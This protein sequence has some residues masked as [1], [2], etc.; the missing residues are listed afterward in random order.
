MAVSAAPRA[1]PILRLPLP[2]GMVL[3]PTALAV[4]LAFYLMPA[5]T[6]PR[7]ATR[8]PRDWQLPLASDV[9]AFMAWLVG[10]EARLGPLAFRDL[11]RGLAWLLDWPLA[12]AE[13]LLVKG[14][15]AGQGAE[16]VQMAPPLPWLSLLL[17]VTALAAHAGGW[18]LA[19]L[20]GG[21]FLYLAA[22]GQWASA[23]TT[24]A[25]IAVAVPL[26]AAAGLLLGI[27]GHRWP[28][29]ERAMAPLLDLMQTV[30]VFAYLVPILFLFGFGPVAAMIATVVYAVPPMIRV[31]IL[32]LRAV[33]EEVVSFGR[34]AGCTRRQLTWRVL[35]PVARPGLMLGL[36]QVI[37]LSLNM[38]IIAAMIGAGGLG[39]DV[40]AAL[41]RLDI[42]HGLEA[43]LAITLLAIALDRLSQGLAARAAAPP[44]HG[45]TR[46]ADLGLAAAVAA[47]LLLWGLAHP[48][49]ALATYPSA[50]QVSTA[51]FWGELVRW[52][53]VH[54]FESLEA[55][56]TAV[57]LNLLVPVKRFLLAQP[58]PWA[59]LLLA[60]AGWRLGGPRLAATVL[61]LGAFVAL[62]GQWENAAVTVYLCGVSVVI[63][64][65]VGVPLGIA[66]A[67]R[68]R[69]G[70]VLEAVLDL[71]QTLP[72]FVY[73]IPVVMLFRVG[74]FTAM[75]AIVLYALAPAARY[76]MHG[77]RQVAP[78]LVEAGVA[79][80]CTRR[81]LLTRV[82][83]PLA[84]PE[85]LLGLNQ[86]V[87]L[88]LSMLVITAL[89]GTRDL[90]QEVY[91][92]LA[93]ADVGRGV[94]AGLCVA[95]IAMI[96]DRLIAAG[97]SRLRRRLGLA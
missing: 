40:L 23:M 14:F 32:S 38:T 70:Q 18:R 56:K 96:A 19:A 68:P 95:A 20:V 60:V 48:F 27:A 73:L 34:M 61:A 6:L 45:A 28:R 5:G 65:L 12:L 41:R 77:L 59:L 30:P 89:V 63:A 2:P 82:R 91:V 78:P 71:L 84:L 83:L 94:V 97:T 53:N 79:A 37:M 81:Q 85:I 92:A 13:A 87:M 49:P 88:A 22:F 54:L 25:S 3:W 26:G 76:T 58:W 39:F 67:A 4:S 24:L 35:V 17:L 10:P 46:R 31:T 21:C 43:G 47:S 62:A 42:G 33:P 9:S 51:P 8:F 80:G 1:A 66:G 69:F 90:G 75:I 7:W 36:N 72:S 57:L 29:F 15:V 55:L 52:L 74:D 44:L 50:W 64:M 86:T 93:K 11:T 16:A